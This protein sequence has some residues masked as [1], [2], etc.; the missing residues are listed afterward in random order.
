MQTAAAAP[1]TG[2]HDPVTTAITA[3]VAS[4]AYTLDSIA[5]SS[6]LGFAIWRR[7]GC[8]FRVIS[9]RSAGFCDGQ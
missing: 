9:G 1:I 7:L 4:I 2:S 6:T 5:P 8:L 3:P